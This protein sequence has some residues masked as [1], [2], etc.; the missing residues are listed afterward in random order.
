MRGMSVC[1]YG[2]F[3]LPR[4]KFFSALLIGNTFLR[5]CGKLSSFLYFNLRE[6]DYT[7]HESFLSQKCNHIFYTSS[8]Q[9]RLHKRVL[10]DHE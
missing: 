6:N 5:N 9:T 10:S 7:K 4:N 1:V 3:H 8:A 2:I